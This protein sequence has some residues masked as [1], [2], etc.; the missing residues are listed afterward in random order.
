MLG[1]VGEGRVFELRLC[2][3]ERG[4]REG[5]GG[6]PSVG[7]KAAGN[8]GRKIETGRASN[9]AYGEHRMTERQRERKTESW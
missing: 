7:L 1:R 9:T 4:R 5:P 8:S 6:N 3:R 2:A